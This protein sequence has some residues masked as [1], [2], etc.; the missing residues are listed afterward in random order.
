MDPTLDLD[1]LNKIVNI[2]QESGNYITDKHNFSF[3]W[4]NLDAR[5]VN[6]ISDI[7]HIP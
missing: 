6:A 3:D 1:S 2:I 4:F 7:L 5:T